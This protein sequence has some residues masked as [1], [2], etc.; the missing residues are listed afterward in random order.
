MKFIYLVFYRK[1]SSPHALILPNP[2][3]DARYH[4]CKY[5]KGSRWSFLQISHPYGN[6]LSRY[7]RYRVITVYRTLIFLLG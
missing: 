3:P 2:L 1:K 6:Q 7:V 4:A 5:C